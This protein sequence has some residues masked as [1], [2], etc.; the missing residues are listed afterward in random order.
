MVKNIIILPVTSFQDSYQNK[1]KKK[2]RRSN[3]N[4]ENDIINSIQLQ[5]IQKHATI[6]CWYE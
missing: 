2:H 6:L 4:D 3:N 5:I 1:D